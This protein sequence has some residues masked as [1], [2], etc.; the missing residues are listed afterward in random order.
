MAEA[1]YKLSLEANGTPTD[2]KIKTILEGDLHISWFK[3]FC[4]RKG[5]TPP[6]REPRKLNDYHRNEKFRKL[7]KFYYSNTDGHPTSLPAVAARK[8]KMCF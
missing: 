2:Y 1:T 6:R 4:A 3:H 7:K 5:W 8:T